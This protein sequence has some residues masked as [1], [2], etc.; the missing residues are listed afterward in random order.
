VPFVIYDAAA[1]SG[2]TFTLVKEYL[3]LILQNTNEGYYKYILAITFTNKAVAE[4]KQRIIKSLSSFAKEDI[5]INPTDMASQIAEETGLSLEKIQKQSN[6]VLKHLLHN[7]SKFSVETIDS[8]NHRLIRTFSREL[9]LSG[10]FEVSLDTPKIINEA[11]D[12][13]IS[14]AGEN[15][16]DWRFVVRKER[17]IEFQNSYVKLKLNY[18]IPYVFGRYF[19]MP[20]LIFRKI[21]KIIFIT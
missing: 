17:E 7:Y 3:K 4:M 14:K 5:L 2:K 18:F 10:N 6:I 11:V 8:F 13:L 16:S 20:I 12:L 9:K 1:G 15:R 21:K 19:K